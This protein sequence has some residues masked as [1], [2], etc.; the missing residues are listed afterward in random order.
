MSID[1]VQL[2]LA[3]LAVVA[4]AGTVYVLASWITGRTDVLDQISSSA[5]MLAW[6]VATTATAGSLYLSEVAGYNP[7]RLCWWQRYAMYPLILV[8][9]FAI[10]RR[11][12]IATWVGLAMTTVG[13][14]IATYH[15]IIQRLPDLG[16]GAC[17]VSAPCTGRYMEEL[18]FITIPTMALVGFITIG[19][20][21]SLRLTRDTEVAP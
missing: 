21:L 9:G 15:V 1:T 6:L 14:G 7:C 8:L 20:L 11:V 19:V 4:A 13:A 5:L 10:I 17:S 2:F 18:G 12:R 16:S 3:L